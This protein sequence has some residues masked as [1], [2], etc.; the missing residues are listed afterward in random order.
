[1]FLWFNNRYKAVTSLLASMVL[2]VEQWFS[3]IVLSAV[4]G[5][6]AFFVWLLAVFQ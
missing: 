2:L 6:K 1:M 5:S 4:H 3:N